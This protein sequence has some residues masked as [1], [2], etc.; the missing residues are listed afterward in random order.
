MRFLH[1]SDWHLGRLFHGVH[2]TDDQAHV[3]DQVVCL[4]AESRLDAVIVAGDVFD[5]AVPP[6]DAVSL[7]DDVLSRLVLQARVPV[8]LV[9]G[10]H[11]SGQRLAFGARLLA[12]QGLHVVGTLA[13]AWEPILFSD[14]AG[15]VALSPLP[16]AEPIVVRQE[17]GRDGLGD[18]DAA[19]AALVDEL[20]AR[21]VGAATRRTI[22]V[23]HTLV[24]GAQQS[25]SERPLTVSGG[26]GVQAARFAPFAYVA[27]GHLHRAQAIGRESLRYSGS[28]LKY[29]FSEAAQT[30]SASIVE[31]GSTGDC[32]VETI[33]LVPRRDVRCLE[34]SL[35]EIL[36]GPRLGES[37][38]D[39]LKIT[40]RDEGPILDLAG[41]VRQV[42]PNVL[43]VERPPLVAPAG[44]ASVGG[45]LGGRS[46]EELFAAFFTEVT[47]RQLGAEEL[48]VYHEAV[49]SLRRLE[50]EVE[51]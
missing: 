17:L 23:A 45:D 8:V 19:M 50:R 6:P 39:Y 28:L 16:F 48:A 30:K 42:Y 33:P 3:L 9:A 1:T 46:D 38:E 15:P 34:G 25:D 2:L 27:L 41:K 32:R 12:G 47:G 44:H 14:A 36:A 51:T 5:R 29:S 20:E 40:V 11:D 18:H 24:V 26:G 10:N 31:M 7:L 4:A 22:L 21:G 49:A 37:R 13:G 35:P 43:A